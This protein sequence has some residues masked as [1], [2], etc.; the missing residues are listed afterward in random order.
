MLTPAMKEKINELIRNAYNSQNLIKTL[1]WYL[2]TDFDCEN[3][4]DFAMGYFFGAF[5]SISRAIVEYEKHKII[6]ERQKKENKSHYPREH[7]KESQKKKTIDMIVDATLKEMDQVK[8]I[9]K[10]W[11]PQFRE[12]IRTEIDQETNIRNNNSN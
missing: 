5:M 10:G 12:K 3:L 9:L 1:N 7:K 11:I 2:K 4:E 8:D 6:L